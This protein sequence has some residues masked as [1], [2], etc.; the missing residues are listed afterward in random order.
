MQYNITIK[1]KPGILNKADTL[2]RRS[3]Y[4]RKPPSDLETTFPCSMF[5]DVI[6]IN[7]T[8][9][10]L[11]SNLHKHQ[12]Y[13]KQIA[14]KYPLDQN[15]HLWFYQKRIVIPEDNDLRWGVIFL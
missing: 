6:T 4:P 12:T 10:A 7:T 14:N 1:H 15:G 3:D 8:I 13:F 2:S 5:A 11:M 9:P